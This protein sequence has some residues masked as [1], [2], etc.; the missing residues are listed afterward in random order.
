MWQAQIPTVDINKIKDLD[1]LI[2][3]KSWLLFDLLGLLGPQDWLITSPETWHETPSYQAFEKFT[4]SITVVNDVAE[5]GVKLITDFIQRCEDEGQRE[6]L[7]QV[8]EE[9][10]KIYPDFKKRTLSLL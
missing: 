2:S 1:D 6:A 9:H 4:A 8:V 7:I 10:R 3:S 5:R